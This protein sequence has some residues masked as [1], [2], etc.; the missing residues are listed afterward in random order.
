[1]PKTIEQRVTDIEGI[2]NDLPH[3]LDIRFEA[4]DRRFNR[5][6]QDIVDLKVQVDRLEV[7]VEAIPRAVAEMIDEVKD[8]IRSDMKDLKDEINGQTG[9]RLGKIENQMEMLLEIMR[10][11]SKT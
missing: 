1:M 4:V 5:I 7:K 11:S 3:I 9:S 8:E 6:E 10:N 2:Y